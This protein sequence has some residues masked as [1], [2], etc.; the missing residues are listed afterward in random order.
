MLVLTL[1]EPYRHV[2][3]ILLVLPFCVNNACTAALRAHMCED[4]GARRIG[5]ISD[6]AMLRMIGIPIELVP[7]IIEWVIRRHAAAAIH[8]FDFH[9]AFADIP[10]LAHFRPFF[11]QFFMVVER[12]LV[13]RVESLR[14]FRMLGL[15]HFLQCVGNHGCLLEAF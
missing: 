12:L 6:L 1:C 15:M 4:A 9:R 3:I 11:R 2:A 14:P 7:H 13:L 10:L 5:P 8:P